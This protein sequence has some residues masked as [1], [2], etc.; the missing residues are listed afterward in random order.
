VEP[1]RP[2]P[3]AP[4]PTEKSGDRSEESNHYRVQHHALAQFFGEARGRNAIDFFVTV[5][6]G[7]AHQ[8]FLDDQQSLR[9]VMAANAPLLLDL[10]NL[11]ANAVNF[12]GDPASAAIEA[13][14]RLPL[15]HG[16]TVH[17]AGGR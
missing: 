3:S 8:I 16:G 15:D 4:V 17:I 13:L 5:L 2:P 9:L 1:N 7:N 6:V 14:S 11:Y 12:R 10:H